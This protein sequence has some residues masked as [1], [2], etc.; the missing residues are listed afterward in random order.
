VILRFGWITDGFYFIGLPILNLNAAI[1]QCT[2]KMVL[3]KAW[4][5]IKSL[6]R[7]N[8]CKKYT[9]VVTITNI[10]TNF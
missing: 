8:A 1:N 6:I 4:F 2:Q 3:S 10:C 7:P 9:Y 5:T